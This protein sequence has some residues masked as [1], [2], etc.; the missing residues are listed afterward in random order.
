MRIASFRIARRRLG[1]VTRA[2]TVRLDESDHAALEHQAEQLRV[3][4]GTLAR[5]LLHAGLSGAAPGVRDARAH[6]ALDRL[7]RRSQERGAGDAVSL[8][9]EA[10]VDLE[11]DG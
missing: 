1:Y 3:K 7:V 9:A 10:R 4:P 11:S 2:I 5:M 6:T 8:V